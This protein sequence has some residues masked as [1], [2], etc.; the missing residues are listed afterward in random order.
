MKTIKDK[1]YSFNHFKKR[2]KE[3][4][5]L[6]ITNE[7][8]EKLC[9]KVKIYEQYKYVSIEIQKHDIQKVYILFFKGENVKVVFSESRQLITTALLKNENYRNNR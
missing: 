7:E 5:N 8:Y 1:K 6:H 4:Y 3:R 2:L 9:S